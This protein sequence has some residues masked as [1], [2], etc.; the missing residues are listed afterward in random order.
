[1]QT[2]KLTPEV[3]ARRHALSVPALPKG[4]RLTLLDNWKPDFQEQHRAETIALIDK[5]RPADT[6]SGERFYEQFKN[7]GRFAFN[8]R[9]P[10]FR[11]T[12]PA[13]APSGFGRDRIDTEERWHPLEDALALFFGPHNPEEEL[14]RRKR[15][16]VAAA[17]EERDRQLR[18]DRLDAEHRAKREY[19]EAVNRRW[20]TMD[21]MMRGILRNIDQADPAVRD[22]LL[23]IVRAVAAE[24]DRA[25]DRE[26]MPAQAMKALNIAEYVICERFEEEK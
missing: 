2:E 8:V 6:Q 7:E 20:A 18:E 16:I 24:P 25:P 5:L 22:V 12:H 19:D 13:S 1:M 15:A 9:L 10:V 3:L 23:F 4:A 11:L 17:R 26:A 14:E 21:R